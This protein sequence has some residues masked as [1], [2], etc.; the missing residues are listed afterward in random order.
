MTDLKLDDEIAEVTGLGNTATGW[1]TKVQ[2]LLNAALK[3]NL[4]PFG[5]AA[6]KDIADISG[7]SSE[8]DKIPI[9]DSDGKVPDIF[10]NLPS[11]E[12]DTS[13]IPDRTLPAVKL[14]RGTLTGDEFENKSLGHRKIVASGVDENGDPFPGRFVLGYSGGR[15]SFLVSQDYSIGDMKTLAYQPSPLPSGWLPCEG[16][17]L[18]RTK[19]ANLFAILATT[20]GNVDNDTFNLPDLRNRVVVGKGASDAFSAIGKTGGA[21]THKMIES[22]MPNHRHFLAADE[23]SSGGTVLSATN[24]IAKEYDGSASSSRTSAYLLRGAVPGAGI[25]GEP[26]FG[27]SSDTGGDAAHTNLQPYIVMYHLIYTGITS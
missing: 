22:E 14:V 12:I 18:S 21:E 2:N 24:Y 4:N 11:G 27:L 3:S 16:Q 25:L 6:T 9:L 13:N 23:T 26:A 5:T 1:A 17:S 15:F 8:Q 20:Y 19:Y 7:G 10:I